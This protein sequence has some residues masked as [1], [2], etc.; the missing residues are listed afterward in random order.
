MRILGL[1]P[2]FVPLLI[3]PASVLCGTADGC[4][5]EKY[6]AIRTGQFDEGFFVFTSGS[7]WFFSSV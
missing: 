7:H 6:I 1:F 4:G 5:N 2:D 3:G